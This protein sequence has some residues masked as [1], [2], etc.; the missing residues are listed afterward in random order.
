MR[1]STNEDE[2]NCAIKEANKSRGEGIFRE[3]EVYESLQR[4]AKHRYQSVCKAAWDEFK[5][6]ELEVRGRGGKESELDEARQWRDEALHQAL[7]EFRKEMDKPF[8]VK[9]NGHI[10]SINICNHH[11]R[12]G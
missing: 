3:V 1:A 6:Y 9:E 5:E 4:W 7:K 12:G 2:V 10:K 11:R 8:A